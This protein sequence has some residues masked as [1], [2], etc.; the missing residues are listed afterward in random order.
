MFM[1]HGIIVKG[2]HQGCSVIVPTTMADSINGTDG[3]WL[4]VRRDGSIVKF[5]KLDGD[6]EA[7]LTT[8]FLRV[9]DRATHDVF[10]ISLDRIMG[11]IDADG[12]IGI[13]YYC[14][15]S[16]EFI[17]TTYDYNDR[18]LNRIANRICCYGNDSDKFA[19]LYAKR[20]GV[21]QD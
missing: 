15:G 21:T 6:T 5:D 11:I 19:R 2:N 7:T 3:I 17:Y 1:I 20:A 10:F 13:E 16:Y 8:N 14:G 4:L 9:V 12:H 18:N